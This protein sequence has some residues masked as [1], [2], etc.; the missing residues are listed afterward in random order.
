[1]EQELSKT[2][3]I[4]QRQ[5]LLANRF[6]I[7]SVLG[8]GAA[9][10]VYKVKDRHNSGKVV[11]LKILLHAD[12]FDEN[13]RERFRQEINVACEFRHPNIVEAYELIGLDNN[14]L[15]YTM[16]YVE[17]YDLGRM[18]ANDKI[19]YEKIDSIFGQLL[20]GLQALHDKGYV[21]RDIK[22]ENVLVRPDGVVKISD[23]GLMKDLN[24]SSLTRTGVLLGT[25]QYMPPEYI[26][27]STYDSRGDLY[28]VGVLLYEI[29][30]KKRRLTDRPGMQAIE[31]LLKTKFELPK[32]PLEG[33]AR[34]YITIIERAT[35][36]KPGKRF[37][38]AAEMKQAFSRSFSE[39]NGT[40]TS[41][42]VV[43]KI[44]VSKF[45][46]QAPRVNRRTSIK[47]LALVMVFSCAAVLS[48]ALAVKW[49]LTPRPLVVDLGIF[50][51]LPLDYAGEINLVAS[52]GKALK[53]RA[54]RRADVLEL[55]AE[56]KDC[57]HASISL[58]VG[59][60]ECQPAGWTISLPKIASEI[61]GDV[62]S[63]HGELLGK[64]SLKPILVSVP[65]E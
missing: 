7:L 16:E 58:S 63:A 5:P 1:M 59:S 6:E 32:L 34:K 39:A 57:A 4:I 21:H 2:T 36:V 35:E 28:A 10:A 45:A 47:K 65:T 50:E 31:H 25:A 13:T 20:D 3:A 15:A 24:N 56:G 33:T 51:K 9:G 46:P 52:G 11:A 54:Y 12:A 38:S 17:G 22:L 64:I 8:E 37:Q 19:P 62:K 61:S 49:L 29:L 55:T 44:R 26:K 30:T 42:P 53:I 27:H 43:S 60:G 18:F 23:L 14:T 40:F 48:T 41:S